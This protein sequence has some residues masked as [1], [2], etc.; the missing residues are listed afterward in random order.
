MQL[1]QGLAAK[2]RMPMAANLCDTGRSA[3]HTRRY[4]NVH[5]ALESIS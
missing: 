1:R 3:V 4:F 2:T 5:D